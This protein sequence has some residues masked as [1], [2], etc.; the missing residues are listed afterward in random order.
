MFIYFA[1]D[2]ENSA[3]A[4]THISNVRRVGSHMLAHELMKSNWRVLV[5]GDEKLMVPPGLNR[6]CLRTDGIHTGI[7]GNV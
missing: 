4:I 2:T 7:K 1:W 5:Q 6:E 3:F